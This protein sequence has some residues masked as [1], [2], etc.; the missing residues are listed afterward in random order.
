IAGVEE[1]LLPHERSGAAQNDDEMEEERRL[2]F[3]G[4]TRAKSGL[5]VSHARYRTI[6]GQF[7]R[8]VPSPFLFELGVDLNE[9]VQ[10]D[11]YEEEETIQT[12][13]EFQPGQLVRHEKF[14]LGRIKEY[15]DIGENSIAVIR[16]NSGQTKTLMLKYADLSKVDI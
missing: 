8:V 7:M 11:E 1:G 16:F 5:Y 4:I 13:P 12:V 9:E 14:G 3:V 2:F 6:R 10:E 15:M